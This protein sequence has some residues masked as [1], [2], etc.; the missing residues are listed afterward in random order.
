MQE[1]RNKSSRR[2]VTIRAGLFVAAIAL[3]ASLAASALGSTAAKTISVAIVANPQMQ[4][5]ATLTPSL[6]TAKT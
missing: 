5:I 2:S 1:A 4:D 6:F 3:V